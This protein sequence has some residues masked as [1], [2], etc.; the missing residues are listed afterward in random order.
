MKKGWLASL[1]FILG[2]AVSAWAADGL[3]AARQLLRAGEFA[4]A[5]AVLAPLVEASVET[6]EEA[7][8]LRARALF[9][10]GDFA[11]SA[12]V[13]GRLVDDHPESFWYYKARFL[14]AQCLAEQ[15]DYR[16]AEAIYAAEAHRLLSGE[17]KKTVARAIVE[18]ADRLA[19]EAAPRALDAPK[20]A[21]LQAHHLYNRALKLEIER[22]LRDELMFKA[23]RTMALTGNHRNAISLYQNYLAE[24]DPT[25]TGPVGGA[26]RQ[27]RLQPP[28]AGAYWRQARFRLAGAL[29][30]DGQRQPARW[31]S[32]NLLAVVDGEDD[33][34]VA[35]ADLR[36]L[37]VQSYQLP[38]V[39]VAEIDFAIAAARQFR[40]RHGDDPRAM[41]AA[42]L[43]PQT[44]ERHGRAE[45]AIAAW[46]ELLDERGFRLPPAA[47]AD[48]EHADLGTTPRQALAKWRQRALF[49]IGQLRFEQGD[50]AAAIENWREYVARFP[51]G[52][53]WSASQNGIVNARFEEGMKALAENRHDEARERL[54]EFLRLYPLDPR[55]PQIL[56]A[57]G[58]MHEARAMELKEAGAA[59]QEIAA[60]WRL[61]V[62]EWEN[63]IGRFG[64]GEEAS[65]AQYRSGRIYEEELRDFDQA[66]QTYRSLDWGAWAADARL[67]LAMMTA[68]SLEVET[69]RTFRT[70][71]QPQVRVQTRNMETLTVRLYRLDIEAYFRKIHDID[72]VEKLDVA[73]IEPDQTWTVDVAGYQA[74]LPI[75]TL[76]DIPFAEGSPGAVVVNVGDDAN[77]QG[78]TLVLRSDL[79]LIFKASRRQALVFVQDMVAGGAAAGTRVLLSDGET[80]FASGTTGADG[81]LQVA[82]KELDGLDKAR[83]LVVRDG[84]AAAHNLDLSGLRTTSGLTPKGYIYTARTAYRPGE[85]VDFRGVL[86]DVDERGYIVPAPGAFAVAILD[87][88]GRLLFERDVELS[89]FG[90]FAAEFPLPEQAAVGDYTI[91]ARRERENQPPLVFTGAFQVRHFKLEQIRLELAFAES[92]YFR[93]ETVRATLQATYYWG[94]PLKDAPVLYTLPDGRQLRGRTDDQGKLEFAFE[95][96]SMLPGTLLAFAASLEGENVTLRRTVPLARLGFAARVEVDHET[97]LAGTPFDIVVE[98][99]DPQ[100]RPVA[101]AMTLH[102]LR[103]E[104]RKP[105]RLLDRLPWASV[106]SAPAAEVTV[107]EIRLETDPESGRA[108]ANLTLERGGRYI[109]R[110]VGEDRFGQTV[111]AST[112]L[113]VSD[114]EDATRLRWFAESDT[115]DVGRASR[116]RLHA[117]TPAGLALLTH[118]GETILDYRIARLENGFNEIDFEVAHHHF[119]NMRL[120]VAMI[121]GRHLRTAT[122]DFTVRRQ[123]TVEIRPEK[124]QYAPGEDGRVELRVT[125]QLGRPVVAELSLAMVDQALLAA[126]PD[127]LPSI[128]DFF[129]RDAR[130]HAEFRTGSSCG[131]RYQGV[132]EPVAE[133]EVA[134]RER[135]LREQREIAQLASTRTELR[136]EFAA[137]DG[138]FPV[139]GGQ[140]MEMDMMVADNMAIPRPVEL[141]ARRQMETMAGHAGQV[142]APAPTPEA[143]PEPRVEETGM[144]F[145]LPAVVTDAEGRA[146]VEVPM[147]EKTTQW[148]LHARGCTV[149]TLVGQSAAEVLTRKDFFVSLKLPDFVR[150]SD[151]L[152]VVGRV[153]NLTDAAGPVHL[154]L[155]VT[156]GEDGDRPV[157]TREAV[158]EVTANGG[159]EI[160]FGPFPAPPELDV[161]LTLTARLDGRADALRRRLPVIPWG[162]DYA[163]HQGGVGDADATALVKLPDDPVCQRQW[164]TVV[165]GPHVEQ[166]IVDMA[167]GRNPLPPTP[168]GGRFAPLPPIRGDTVGGELLAVIS[169]FDYAR[170][171]TTPSPEAGQLE[172]RVRALIG[173]L[174]ASQRDDGGWV[175]HAGR[176]QQ[177]DWAIAAQAYWALIAARDGGF[178]IH[179]QT[180][181]KAA[182]YLQEAFR[183]LGASDNQGKA[184]IL[185][186]LS[187]NKL[188]DFAHCNR[189][190]RERNG[191]GA[192]TLAYT[193][194]A[195]VNLDRRE[196]AGELLDVLLAKVE[197]P[198]ADELGRRFAHWTHEAGVPRLAND[199]EV[200]ALALLAIAR[201]RPAA[202]SGQAAADWLLQRWGGDGRAYG[203]ARGTT[204]A[205]LAAWFDTA[206]RERA[207]FVVDILVNGHP[208]TRFD[209]QREAGSRSIAVPGEMLVAGENRVEFRKRGAGVYTYAVTLQGFATEIKDPQSWNYPRIHHR[210]IYHSGLEYRGRP[211]GVASSTQI[212]KLK[213]GQR[214]RVNV[215][216]N[217][218]H[219]PGYLVIEEPLPAGA[220]LVPDSIKG[221][222]AHHEIRQDRIVCFFQVNSSSADFTYELIGYAPGAYRM[223][224]TIMRDAIRP[225]RM[226]LGNESQLTIL[227]PGEVSDEAYQMNHVEL[228]ALGRA[229]FADGL[230]ADALEYLSELFRRSR[231]YNE[232]DVA[233]MLLWILTE[234]RHYEPR[235]IVEMFEILRERHPELEIPFDKIL[236]VGRAYRD[237]D[238]FERAW[239]I[240]R[241]TVAAS[242]VSDQ[243]IGVILEQVGRHLVSFDYQLELWRNYPDSADVVSAYFALTQALYSKVP[244][245]H[246]LLPGADGIKP[247]RVALLRRTVD[248]LGQFLT[249]YPAD[250]LADD[251]GFSLANAFLELQDYPMVVEL[252]I[253]FAER[254][255][256]SPLRSSF[257]YMT[258]L[259]LF[260]QG[261]YERAIE[262]ARLVADKETE[263]SAFARYI[264]GQIHHARGNPAAA[265]EWYGKVADAYPDAAQTIEYF[266]SK[267]VGMEEVSIVRPGRPVVLTLRH[268]N[269]REAFLQV[270]RVDLMKL[271]LREKNLSRIAAIHLAGIAP[272]FELRHAFGDGRDFR[273][274]ETDIELDLGEEGAYLV[275]FR[276]DDLFT[277]GL[278][279]ITPLDI[280][281]QE[282]PDSG[283]L[284]VNVVDAVAG[285]YRAEVHVKAIGSRDADFRDGKTDLRGIFVAD[286]LHGQATVIAREGESRYAF[287][288]GETWFGPRPEER[289]PPPQPSAQPPLDYQE[290]LRQRNLDMQMMNIQQFNQT[291]DGQQRGVQ[292]KQAF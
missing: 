133:A 115:L 19:T 221:S 212:G 138:R 72:S 29:L 10:A 52:A 6:R 292:V 236:V 255:A 226:R 54:D 283:R 174:V 106:R 273:D 145:W 188:A 92:V 99:T 67:R 129:Q 198:P 161:Y 248:L 18:L 130:R 63:L 253:R 281:V 139:L 247:E 180:L 15:K 11:A 167:L 175:W 148:Q 16:G 243:A 262:V 177:S 259:G 197:T 53:E 113:E 25:Y 73:L 126:F 37:I 163:D 17:R 50:Y 40:A 55:A 256:A 51:H 216:T 210:R 160:A 277:S 184:I 185:H 30:A 110:A 102:V 267:S 131:F 246:Q 96:A 290:N 62:A 8:H 94:E 33:S 64:R 35:A 140:L 218:H 156:T 78:T 264:V 223:P 69:Q 34:P 173:S 93:G 14:Q 245:A 241:A 56:F 186:A 144:G 276:G 242:F 46:Q 209:S 119:P 116:V 155:T 109:L 214:A 269:L 176:E 182:T 258:A 168:A 22:D 257:Q 21:Y 203:Q 47:V 169:A 201:T 98:A 89:P 147:P 117:R 65:L 165:V 122:R 41:M 23:A 111:A 136:R 204:L 70:D 125:D 288:R 193:A 271:Y 154:A 83:V 32:E 61:A 112:T 79:E 289:R 286:G 3:S 150:E 179:D 200:T 80:V 205:A 233:R 120:A 192:A 103:R 114:D 270:Y 172:R 88:G 77:W 28:P 71:E 68:K 265:I 195:F 118:E 235:R 141:A 178:A 81:V 227:G 84:H 239:L 85:T 238:E 189:L 268:R 250:P 181:S 59:A 143:A 291:R 284:R 229:Y 237:I 149:E 225:G 24:F 151:E 128:L 87:A 183:R 224:P 134:E 124:A 127:T 90:T 272:A 266:E 132:V 261:A 7:L 2:L 196:I 222:F 101:T 287:H 74:Y 206:R 244:H 166:A 232:R 9:L 249:L 75:E 13:A 48:V 202:E 285:G 153:H 254:F 36:W 66:L 108:R 157:A 104:V 260:W 58:Q 191:L 213:L 31:Q 263:D 97:V 1:A 159:A 194:L 100:G 190:Y 274:R 220:I 107:R 76:I 211:L 135:L 49:R 86:R 27:P 219:F 171:Q 43:I 26:A 137:K 57:F 45:A 121:D 146:M 170:K 20:P 280:E 164:L 142:A 44:L 60:A 4:E 234:P 82:A 162:M 231:T 123:L 240:Y 39:A 282:Y 95:T 251:A 187:T 230:Y 105:D 158:V 5:A 12:T 228:F 252:G 278:V 207:D 275:I 38:E 152:R 208:L 42:W 199:T 91:Q 215:S 217:S 279:L